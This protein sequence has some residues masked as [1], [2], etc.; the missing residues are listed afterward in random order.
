M[1]ATDPDM[2]DFLDEWQEKPES[3][4]SGAL[5]PWDVLVVDD[6]PAVLTVTS[7]VLKDVT[8]GGRAL[9][10]TEAT[11]AAEA[12]THL[13]RTEFAVL[14]LDVVMETERAGLDLVRHL[15]EEI[16]NTRTRIIVRTGQ[17]GCAPEERVIHD[18][19]IND[20]REKTA[21]TAR[22]LESSVVAALRE[23]RHIRELDEAR[24]ALH[25]ERA[26]GRAV[27]DAMPSAVVVCDARGR[28]HYWNHEAEKLSGL[29]ASEVM[30]F[31]LS[32]IAPALQLDAALLQEAARTM[33]PLRQARH[34]SRRGRFTTYRD[35]MFYPAMTTEGR[36]L[37]VRIEDVSDRVRMESLM[38][39]T[40]KMLSLGG[41]AAGMAHEINNPLS[42]IMQGAETVQ[43]RLSS[44]LEGNK[45][46]AERLGLD[47]DI[48]QAYLED[49]RV[50]RFV[51]GIAEAGRRAAGIVDNM[52]SFGR[53]DEGRRCETDI[54]RVVER[55]LELA[56]HHYDLKKKYDFR[57]IRIIRQFDDTLPP[58]SCNP[59]EMEQVI[60][61]LLQNAAQVL[62][63]HPPQDEVPT[64]TLLTRSLD[65]SVEISVTDN[66]PGVPHEH[67]RRI[68]EPF[69]TTKPPGEGTG[70]GLSVSYFIITEHHG[71]TLRLERLRQP[72]HGARFIISLPLAG[73]AGC[74]GGRTTDATG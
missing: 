26:L 18:Y 72:E 36:W 16:G 33:A 30:G 31:P 3:P 13:A 28:I 56:A 7:L 11:S 42:V 55:A 47:L 43:R 14:L 51:N 58:V 15:R 50:L 71:G 53:G 65:R 37:V 20:Y 2:L 41:L 22:G 46:A 24:A 39:Q 60:F 35:V 27:L 9:A 38:L 10:F 21:L 49:R 19:D 17:P 59:I 70:L 61:N 67:M 74:S 63:E 4:P 62:Y 57:L 34:A 54:N 29:A 23:Y 45:A 44:G 64:I 12:R 68:F 66:G 48:M 5:P 40:E 52:L 69:F 25:A 1:L 73:R 32:D 8:F 6:D